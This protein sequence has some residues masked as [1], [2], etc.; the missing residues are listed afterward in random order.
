M[1]KNPYIEINLF[2]PK[3]FNL[4][5]EHI[6]VGLTKKQYQD[7]VDMS[8]VD[9][10]RYLDN[11]ILK[12]LQDKKIFFVFDYSQEGIYQESY[13]L[14]ECLYYNSKLHN[15]D[16]EQI[17]YFTSNFLEKEKHGIKP[18]VYQPWIDFMQNNYIEK[19]CDEAF[20]FTVNQCIKNYNEDIYFSSFNKTW[21]RQWRDYFHYL[22]YKH[23]LLDKGFVS[24]HDKL[25]KLCEGLAIKGKQ[26]LEFKELLPLEFDYPYF[27]SAGKGYQADLYAF[28]TPQFH[29][30]G[31]S[32]YNVKQ[33]CFYSEKSFKPIAFFQPFF[34]IGPEGFYKTLLSRMK[35]HEYDQLHQ[36]NLDDKFE[37]YTQVSRTIPKLKS[38]ITKM[39][40]VDRIDWRF[41]E[42]TKL[43][44]NWRQLRNYKANEK[45]FRKLNKTLTK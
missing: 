32:I 40:K 16:L 38:M 39:N 34:V 11:E 29:I 22:L 35:I 25:G 10:F 24:N 17:I 19:E 13:K 44:H 30:V 36:F 26:F 28:T 3:C 43:K 21:D 1:Q 6:R 7:K 33:S 14:F 2:Q 27:W 45:L 9:I 5:I 4:Q 23:N 18:N 20:E 41:K 31:E 8:N 15:V 37:I 42:E 12:K